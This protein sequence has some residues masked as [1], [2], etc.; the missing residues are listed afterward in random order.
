MKLFFVSKFAPL[1]TGLSKNHR[2]QNASLNMTK[3]S[4]YALD[5]G[6]KVATVSMDLSKA[7]N[8]LNHNLL[9]D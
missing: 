8:T 2:T 6:K 9:L 5:K 1:L 7:F 3:K 4:K